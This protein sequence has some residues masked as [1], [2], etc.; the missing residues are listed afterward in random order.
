MNNYYIHKNSGNAIFVKEESFFIQQG[1]LTAKWG[2][3]W[4]K[5]QA[6]SIEHAREIGARL[7][8]DNS[9]S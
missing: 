9:Y 4:R 7:L 1:G 5:V 6:D 3:A 2:R 8:K